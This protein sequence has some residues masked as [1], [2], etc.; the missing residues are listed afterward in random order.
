MRNISGTA[1]ERS[2]NRQEL[3]CR[4]E[5]ASQGLRV[6]SRY[7]TLLGYQDRQYRVLDADGEMV[8]G[9]VGGM[10]GGSAYGLD[11]CDLIDFTWPDMARWVP[12]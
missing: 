12:E 8:A 1:G 11:L 7:G 6:R 2:A 5:L 10:M 9:S 4:A 3:E